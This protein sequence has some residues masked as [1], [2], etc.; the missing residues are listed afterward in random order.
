MTTTFP[1]RTAA[2]AVSTPSPAFAPVTTTTG[3]DSL[4]DAART[5]PRDRRRVLARL[6]TDV[7][8]ARVTDV[9]VIVDE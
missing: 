3:A 5:T 2:A 7:D 9:D 4:D 1:S 6:P 8:P